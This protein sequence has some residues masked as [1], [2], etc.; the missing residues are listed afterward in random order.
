MSR[1]WKTAWAA[2]ASTGIGR[3]LAL[4]PE[5]ALHGNV[6]SRVNSGLV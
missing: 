3:A 1:P 6:M 2:G 5:P 4:R